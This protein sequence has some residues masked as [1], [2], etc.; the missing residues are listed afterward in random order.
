MGTCWK[1]CIMGVISRSRFR[2]G[3]CLNS[4]QPAVKVQFLSLTL[5]TLERESSWPCWMMS[6]WNRDGKCLQELWH[7]FSV[8]TAKKWV[9]SAGRRSVSPWGIWACGCNIN[10]VRGQNAWNMTFEAGA[11]WLPLVQK[12]PDVWQVMSLMWPVKHLDLT[13][14]STEG[15]FLASVWMFCFQVIRATK[16]VK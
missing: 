6:G 9:S 13:L 8:T 5:W 2:C 7:I 16:V 4:G 15:S 11:F 3:L 1:C 10:R 12:W 14:Q